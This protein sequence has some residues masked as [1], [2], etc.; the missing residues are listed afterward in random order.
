MIFA[1][2]AFLQSKGIRVFK[3]VK[4]FVFQLK[5]DISDKLRW[6]TRLH[7]IIH[8][9]YDLTARLPVRQ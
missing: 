6:K 7:K 1:K 8:S 2:P 9:S 4:F 5:V 3:V